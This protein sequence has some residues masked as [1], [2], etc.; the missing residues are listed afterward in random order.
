MST[1]PIAAEDRAATDAGRSNETQSN[2]FNALLIVVA[3]VSLIAFIAL[4]AALLNHIVFPFDQPILAYF[5]ALD[6]QPA[7]WNA[8][9]QSANFPLIGI[10][11]R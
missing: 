9:S 5:R 4:T 6:G 8:V 2:Q 1:V 11:F 7:L 10:G 3:I